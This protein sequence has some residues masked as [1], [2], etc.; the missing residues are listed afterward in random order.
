MTR[1]TPQIAAMRAAREEFG[2]LT[3]GMSGELI[4][5]IHQGTVP[6]QHQSDPNVQQALK[7]WARCNTPTQ[8][9]DGTLDYNSRMA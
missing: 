2:D 6:E 9:D 8:Y 1:V 7:V 3:K 4:R 5:D